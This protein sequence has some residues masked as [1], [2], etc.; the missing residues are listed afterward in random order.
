VLLGRVASRGDLNAP[1]GLAPAPDGF[2]RFGGDLLVGNGNT[3]EPRGQVR[4]MDGNR[5]AIDGLWALEFGMGGAN[6]GPTSTLFFTAGPDDE[7]NG[8]SGRSRPADHGADN[9]QPVRRAA[10]SLRIPR[11]DR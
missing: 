10:G 7:S 8:L 3:F 5:I 4:D 6:N 1:W 9:R 11:A 2:G